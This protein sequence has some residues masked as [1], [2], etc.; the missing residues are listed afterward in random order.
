MVKGVVHGRKAAASTTTRLASKKASI[1]AGASASLVISQGASPHQSTNL[2][3]GKAADV[4]TC[5]KCGKLICNDTKALQCEKCDVSDNWRCIECLDM[6]PE[7]YDSLIGIDGKDLHWFCDVCEGSILSLSAGIVPSVS[8]VGDKRIDEILSLLTQV[9]NKLVSTEAQ[10]ITKADSQ[11]VADLATQCASFD[12]RLTDVDDRILHLESEV[13][14]LRST[15]QTSSV[16][17]AVPYSAVAVSSLTSS[18]TPFSHPATDGLLQINQI[19]PSEVKDRER[20]RQN[21][22]LYKV[23]EQQDASLDER[24]QAD[25]AYVMSLWDDVFK[26]P[27]VDDDILRIYRIGSVDRTS[28]KVRPILIGFKED[29]FR[30]AALDNLKM[31]R[32]AS[33]QYAGV[34]LSQD[35]SPQQREAKRQ[36]VDTEKARLIQQ[37][38]SLENWH[39][40]V[41][42]MDSRVRVITVSQ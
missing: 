26:T 7:V 27:I 16:L 14:I 20:R 22:I 11:V 39:Y 9:L 42:G 25:K 29:R 3:V 34:S 12:S 32:S 6:K 28:S 4:S 31:L 41:V 30:Q 24:R 5:G 13:S 35:Y 40:R 36:A 33:A 17:P 38:I 15:T 23:P 10:I 21:L 37:G 8:S 2:G 18:A 19:V 1:K